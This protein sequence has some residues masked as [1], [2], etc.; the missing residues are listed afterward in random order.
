MRDMK[1]CLILLL[2]SI[3]LVPYAY[4][5]SANAVYLKDGRRVVG[6]VLNMD[7]VGDV[8]IQTTDGRLM[9]LPASQVDNI[10]WSYEI[11]ESGA[12]AIYRYADKY[13]W[14]RND[15]EL[16]DRDYERFFDDDLYHTYVGGSNQFN[17]GGACWLYSFTCAVIAIMN[18]DYKSR[19]QD[20]SVYI[21]AA[22]A[23]VLACL[24]GVFT[25]IGKGRLNW[26]EKTF[27][28]QNAATNE[29]S[30]TSKYR[31]SFK[32]NP[33]ILMSAQHDLALGATLSLSF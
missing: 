2:L 18:I 9:T 3:I 29:V 10:N 16:S 28:E 6:Y 33:S 30:Y 25:G 17:I 32:L 13:R 22:G 31:N 7:S 21:Y 24:G 23:N 26:V 8:R 5:Q 4:S 27:N 12:G 19:K 1:R 14:V 15:L 11:K 20:N